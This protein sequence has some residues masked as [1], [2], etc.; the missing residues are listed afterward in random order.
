M[1]VAAH[2]LNFKIYYVKFPVK[3]SINEH[4]AHGSEYFSISIIKIA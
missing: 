1:G 2:D 4:F 3:L